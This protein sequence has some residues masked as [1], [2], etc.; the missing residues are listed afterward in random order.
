MTLGG[1]GF[2]FVGVGAKVVLTAVF[3]AVANLAYYQSRV[4]GGIAIAGAL[5]MR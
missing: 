4:C 2:F 5:V 1:V 3:A